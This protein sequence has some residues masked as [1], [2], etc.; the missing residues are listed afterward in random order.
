MKENRTQKLDK[1]KID[2]RRDQKMKKKLLVGIMAIL[3]II[4][5]ISIFQV[6]SRTNTIEQKMQI[7]L[8]SKGYNH[9]DIANIEVK[10]SFLNILLSYNQWTILVEY[11]D[12]PDV[13]YHYTIKN[14]QIVPSG[15][16]GGSIEME[17]EDLKHRD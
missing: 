1:E 14:N 16:S 3:I 15:I 17:K 13:L 9:N 11:S 5:A 2:N 6:L 7:Y 4:S 8:A 12:E 10:H